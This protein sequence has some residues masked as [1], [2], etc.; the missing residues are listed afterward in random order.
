LALLRD[1]SEADSS[2]SSASPSSRAQTLSIFASDDS[3]SEDVCLRLRCADDLPPP[4][5][6]ASDSADALLEASDFEALAA[7]AVTAEDDDEDAGAA[8]AA[9][10][11]RALAAR[12]VAGFADG[13]DGSA[14][15]PDDSAALTRR[16]R[17][18]VARADAATSATSKARMG[19]DDRCAP[20]QR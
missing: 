1:S 15:V 14:P 20:S 10:D 9:A 13:A 19:D 3:E 12:P 5:L 4:P 7:L 8:A 18:V 6:G 17:S 11:L 2:A 16:T